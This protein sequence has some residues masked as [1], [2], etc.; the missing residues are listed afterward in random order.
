VRISEPKRK[1]LDVAEE[2]HMEKLLHL[3]SSSDITVVT[4]SIKM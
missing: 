1:N 4:K 3:Y 2:M